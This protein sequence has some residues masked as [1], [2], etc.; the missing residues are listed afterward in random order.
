MILSILRGLATFVAVCV[1][2]AVML[3]VCGIVV[4]AFVWSI[5]SR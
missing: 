3:F 2:L 1:G 5:I 4:P